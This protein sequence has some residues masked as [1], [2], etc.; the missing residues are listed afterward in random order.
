MLHRA[1][2]TTSRTAP[3]L[4][5]PFRRALASTPPR[6]SPV[7]SQT[8]VAL[9][10][11]VA[12]SQFLKTTREDALW[13]P[14]LLWRDEERVLVG[15]EAEARREER[16][17]KEVDLRPADEGGRPTEKMNMYQAIRDAMHTVLSKDESALI[18]GEDVSFGG[19][20][21]CTMGLA[22]QFGESRVFN[23]PL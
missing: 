12:T 3:R 11:T 22:D 8:N 10:P 5:R 7:N 19:V 6:P 4:S 17:L 2:L 16:E 13:S 23:T 15:R 1:T 18:F 14:G 20:F 21:R 9:P